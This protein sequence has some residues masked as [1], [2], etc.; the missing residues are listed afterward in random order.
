MSRGGKSSDPVPVAVRAAGQ[1]GLGLF[2]LR[3]FA[4][5]EVILQ[6]ELGRVV[7]LDDLSTL[8]SVE[9]EHLGELTATTC[10]VLPS[11]RCYANHACEANAIS[12]DTM[13][14]ARRPIR[15]GEEITIDYRLN[16]LD[17][18]TLRC[19]CAVSAEPHIVIGS[20]LALPPELQDEYLPYAPVF[21]RRAYHRH[22]GCQGR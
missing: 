14:R 2:A 6:W 9:R 1:K 10:Q 7:H 17:D 22:H 13:L 19:E 18:W 3:D 8:D 21:V 12:S 11:P 20:F 4:P 16:A 15:S 5:R